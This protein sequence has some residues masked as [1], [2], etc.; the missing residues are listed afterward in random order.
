MKIDSRDTS[1]LPDLALFQELDSLQIP[2]DR[3]FEDD[4]SAS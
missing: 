3:A 1:D 2:D 4:L